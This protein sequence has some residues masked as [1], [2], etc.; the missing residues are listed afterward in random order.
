ML[1]WIDFSTLSFRRA[2]VPLAARRARWLVGPVGLA[3][4]PTACRR[5][6]ADARARAARRGTIPAARRSRVL[7]RRRLATIFC[8]LALA[9]PVARVSDDAACQRRHRHPAGRLGVDARHRRRAGPLAAIGAV[10]ARIWR[11]AELEGRSRRAGAICVS[12]GAAG[13]ADQG[14]RMRCSSSSITS[15][16]SRRFRSKTTRRW[17]TNIEA[18]RVVGAAARRDGR[19]AVWR[20]QEPEGVRGDL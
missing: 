15:G 2:A 7:G 20:K 12:R 11:G 4:T 6:A 9:R 14:S 19:A 3:G 1:L 5:A 8:I 13:S 18:G 10:S 16:I 17:D